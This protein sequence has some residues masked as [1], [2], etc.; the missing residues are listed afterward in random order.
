MAVIASRKVGSAVRR[1]RAKRRL[2][3]ILANADLP[4]ATHLAVVAGPSVPDV[5][6]DRL[7]NWVTAGL[8]EEQRVG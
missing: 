1:N 7:R 2:R 3:A 8:A 5:D 4:E 6:F